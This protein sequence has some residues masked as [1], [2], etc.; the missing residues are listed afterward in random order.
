MHPNPQGTWRSG[1]PD[2][3]NQHQR[4]KGRGPGARFFPKK[5]DQSR[6]A[7]DY[8]YPEPLPPPPPVTLEQITCQIRRLSPFKASGPNEIPNVILQKCLEQLLDYLVYLFGGIFELRTYYPK[9][10]E[11]TMVVLRKLGKPCYEVPKA[12]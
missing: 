1:Q 2:T 12:Y 11:F 6:V 3:G 7:E 5:P 9:S 4:Q 10:Q 8:E